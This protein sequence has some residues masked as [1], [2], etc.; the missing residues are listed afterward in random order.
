MNELEITLP[1]GNYGK[2][3]IAWQEDE[4]DFLVWQENLHRIASYD[5]LSLNREQALDAARF[6]LAAADPEC[7]VPAEVEQYSRS[8]A[9]EMGWN[10]RGEVKK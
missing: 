6:I 7:I 3:H 8:A 5:L 9:Y 4:N 1:P 10:D 2:T